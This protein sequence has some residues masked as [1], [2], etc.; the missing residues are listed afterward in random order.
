MTAKERLK[1]QVEQD[2]KA[3][4]ATAKETLRQKVQ[5]DR[6]A[7]AETVPQYVPYAAS[8]FNSL[9]QNLNV[10]QNN[11]GR[12]EQGSAIY[13]RTEEG[14]VLKSNVDKAR[15]E[16]YLS[17]GRRENENKLREA[18][19]AY[20]NWWNANPGLHETV[21][22]KATVGE[23]VDYQAG[24]FLKGFGGAVQGTIGFVDKLV[25]DDLAILGSLVDT[26]TG[27]KTQLEK[28]I[29][30]WADNAL[31]TDILGADKFGQNV[32]NSM[33]GIK[34]SKA[35]DFVG[36]IS[37]SA[38]AMLPAIATS[39]AAGM[40]GLGAGTTQALNSVVF[41]SGAAGNAAK[42]AIANGADMADA[43]QYG[44]YSGMLEVLTE[45]MFAGIVGMNPSG[46]MDD[47]VKRLKDKGIA[48]FLTNTL[49]EGVEEGLVAFLTPYVQR[50]TYNPEAA[51]ATWR[52]MMEA[53]ASG[54]A[55]SFLMNSATA[56]ATGS[57]DPLIGSSA[58]MNE[59][60]VLQDKY[61]RVEEQMVS[62]V[63]RNGNIYPQ[64]EKEK[65]AAPEIKPEEKASKGIKA[66]KAESEQEEIPR[67]ELPDV[68]EREKETA[69]ADKELPRM[70]LKAE[71]EKAPEAK[72]VPTS[73][74]SQRET[75]R[76]IGDYVAEKEIQRSSPAD[77]GIEN[78]GSIPSVAVL[79]SAAAE[80]FDLSEAAKIAQEA[81]Y[82]P[83]FVSGLFHTAE[84]GLER[85]GKAG[86]KLYIQADSSNYTAADIAREAI[87]NKS[88]TAAAPTEQKSTS[89]KMP[90]KVI[91][92]YKGGI[93]IDDQYTAEYIASG[94]V[95]QKDLDTINNTAKALG[96]KVRFTESL[97]GGK[98]GAQIQNGIVTISVS[99]SKP[100]RRLF[101]H[102]ITHRLQEL[103]PSAYNQMRSIIG[104][105]ESAKA[106]VREVMENYKSKDLEISE[107]DALDEV[108]AE[109]A[110]SLL[111]DEGAL[112]QLINKADKT[113]IEKLRE[114]FRALADKL[115]GR[116]K[117]QAERVYEKLTEAMEDASEKVSNYQ[118]NGGKKASP[119]INPGFAEARFS[120]EPPYRVGTESRDQFVADLD[121]KAKKTYQLFDNIHTIGE[122][123]LVEM[124]V[125]A[126]IKAHPKRVNITMQYM[127]ASE[128]NEHCDNSAEFAEVAQMLAD[129]LPENVKKNARI[130]NDGRIE[131]TPF[132]KEFKME[133]AFIQRIVDSLPMEVIDSTI[134]SDGR[135]IKVSNKSKVLSVGGEAYRRALV[136]ERR[137]MYRE[138]RLPTK[139]I[140]GLSKDN[141][142]ALGFVATNGKTEATGDFTTFCPQMY[143]NKGC[144]YCYRVASLK[145][146]SNNKL[147][148]ASV[149]YTGEILQLKKKDID[150]LNKTGGLRIQSNGDWMEQYSGQLAD[151]L[152]DA[153]EMGLQIKIITKEPSMIETVALLKEQGIGKNLYFNLSA[154][155]VI[156]AQGEINNQDGDGALPRN[157][158]R[159]F[160]KKDGKT[161]WKRALT[162]EEAAEYRSKYDWVNT[163]IV[164]TTIKEFIAGLRSPYVDVVTGYHGQMRNF[165][166]VSSATGETLV[167]IEAVGDAGMPRFEFIRG[168]W[169]L[170]Y[171]GKTQTHKKLAQAI[172]GAG[173]QWEY[174]IKSC[175]ITG[176]CA[177][178]KGK[179]GKLANIFGV[180]NATNRDAESLAYWQEQMDSASDNPLLVSQME[181]TSG[182]KYSLED[183]MKADEGALE[184]EQKIIRLR[185]ERDEINDSLLYDDLSEIE[186]KRLENRLV[187]VNA[188]L[189]KLITEES[190]A[191]VL[192]PVQTIL[193][194]LDRYRI[195]DL[196]SLAEQISQ[197]SW[198]DY[199]ELSRNELEEALREMIQNQELNPLEMQAPKY[200]YYVRKPA[201]SGKYSIEERDEYDSEGEVLSKEQQEFFKDSVVRDENG[202]LKV[203]YHGTSAG[204]FTV[205]E[206]YGKARYGLFGVGSYF[207]DSKNIAQS[208]TQKGKGQTPKVYEAYLNIKNPMD[209]DATANPDEWKE[210]FPEAQFP[211]NGTNEQFYRA[212]EEYFEDEQYAKWEAAEIAMEA[213]EVMG[214]D[215]IT[216]IGGGR[217]NPNGERHRVYIAFQ[218]EQ[219]K[220]IDNDRPTED[221]DIRYSIED[222]DAERDE[223]LEGILSDLQ[224]ATDENTAIAESAT[225]AKNTKE[226]I[227]V[228]LAEA[229]AEEQEKAAPELL[230]KKMSNSRGEFTGGPALQKLG[231]KI[232]NSVGKYANVQQLLGNAR[233]AKTITKAR[234]DA[235]KR[236]KVTA[237]EKNFARGIANGI[238]KESDIPEGWDKRTVLEMS[239]WY[240][241]E[242]NLGENY[243]SMLKQALTVDMD[244]ATADLFKDID[245]SKVP[246]AI[247]LN[248]RTTQRNMRKIFG[249]KGEEINK[250]LF[251]PVN[252]NEAERIRFVN[253]Q[254]DQ[255]RTFTDQTGKERALSKTERAMVQKVIEGRVVMDALAKLENRKD[256]EMVAEELIKGEDLGD[257]G[258]EFGL[259]LEE[260]DVARSYANWL[261]VTDELE[262]MD[263][264]II[265]SAADKYAAMFD[266]YYDAINEFLASH[267]YQPIG[268]IKGYVPHLQPEQNQT[269]LQNVF[270]RL[271]INTD[272]STLPTSIAGLTADYKPNK[273]WNPYFL[274]RNGT[275]T[276]FDIVEA[277]ESYVTNMADVL[278]HSDDIMRIRSAV[279][280]FRRTYSPEEIRN[281]IE[282]AENLRT[283]PQDEKIAFLTDEG[284]ISSGAGLSNADAKE[285]LNKYI[286]EQYG[287]IENTS[288][289]NNLVVYLDNYANILA[290]KQSMADRGSETALGRDILNKGNK[291]TRIFSTAAVAGNISSALNQ[292]AQLPLILSENGIV[293]TTRAL[294]DI[295]AG[296]LRKANWAGDS[297]YLNTKKGIKFIDNTGY[298]KFLNATFKPMELV[299]GIV[300]TLA[301]RSS[302]LKAIQSG[303][304][305]EDA[306]RYA[307]KKAAAIMG[308]RSKGAKPLA[309]EAKNPISAM[310]HLFQVEALNSWDHIFSDLPKDIKQ[311]AAQQGK[312]QAAKV[313]AG[314]I[315]KGLI[316]TFILNRLAEKLYGGTPA[317]FD[318][319]GITAN[320]I[321]SGQ[322]LGTNSYLEA[323]IDKVLLELFGQ[324]LFDTD[325][326]EL[327]QLSDGEFETGAAFDDLWYN[328]SNEL[329]FLNNLSALLGFGD[330]SLPLPDLLTPAKDVFSGI[331]NRNVLE[332]LDAAIQ[333][334]GE[335]AP[336]G[337]QLVKTY[338]GA[339]TLAQGGKMKGYGAKARLQYPVRPTAGNIAQAL[340]FGTGGMQENQDYYAAGGGTLTVKETALW[341]TLVSNGADEEEAYNAI[342]A[343]KG[344]GVKDYEKLAAMAAPNEWD[345]ELK[346][347]A[348]KAVVSD[349]AGYKLDTLQNFGVAADDYAEATAAMYDF[350][351]ERIA[352]MPEEDRPEKISITQD[353]AEKALKAAKN[354]SNSDKAVIWQMTNAGWSPA[355]NP[356]SSTLGKQAKK[357]YDTIKEAAE[358]EEEMQLQGVE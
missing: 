133:R 312:G 81:G 123:N 167:D 122:E 116:Q 215:G 265:Y 199:E 305:H 331:K 256:I 140:A 309:F 18:E 357:E 88:V 175:C 109:Y 276:Q 46:A 70:E 137:A 263:K 164:A 4:G 19:T 211:K 333:A 337:R 159:P 260:Q 262:T 236:L 284:I 293:N 281:A 249:E 82:E 92:I 184:M 127:L 62:D 296:N 332:V 134:V 341:K 224:A 165:E 74:G 273:K 6:A 226:V 204:G 325:E 84:G 282:W 197:S 40:A 303:M 83:V 155:Y 125:G 339:K 98:V 78:G 245:E 283:M 346:Y 228:K 9:K 200:G 207:T 95:S 48:E 161:Y 121:E 253:R 89:A 322:E 314:V 347:T 308:D 37:E 237:K 275:T 221:P 195:T 230:V 338:T 306:M 128:W 170:E 60:Q 328:A 25:G 231:I 124:T 291:L 103:A 329:P 146:G 202:N 234:Q 227:S 69:A 94:K 235:E 149:W 304:N 201:F 28:P 259:T 106:K 214:Y 90:R 198:D 34:P 113:L 23:E 183:E 64:E 52:E 179:C 353:D 119:D 186:T 297:D 277:F 85:W 20:Q 267:G 24:R 266:N 323:M 11:A 53:F 279:K 143:F 213:I 131:E 348:M 169:R 217:V 321:A 145:T 59:Q 206:P 168:G 178:C 160:M 269:A 219:I 100:L 344:E 151:M 232:T 229:E 288:K 114:V 225:P 173:L 96:L 286:E 271:G 180:K 63:F 141:W 287:K 326:E 139:S 132:E 340:L 336:G 254:L 196:Y 209:M 30:Q 300:S 43:V 182:V 335:I 14:R 118:T 126:G 93:D 188:E 250:W 41:G 268:F 108:V 210:A 295:A 115:T 218:P 76:S 54:A 44:L 51:S 330:S 351:A 148:G 5:A 31:K 156:E 258:L 317:G 86:N 172:E 194:N 49:G 55:M 298:E 150:M 8:G 205:F 57:L 342:Y 91:S 45:N 216:H 242:R 17:G 138:G 358:D 246:G 270:Q 247:V 316:S 240:M 299:D 302:Y 252:Q 278:Y 349:S 257:L 36:G 289:Y 290:G 67:M 324:T 107:L 255:V 68:E 26:T 318:I 162:V 87:A 285:L 315:S 171:E 222:A 310:V 101:G 181:E 187:K 32:E 72:P 313:L 61:G 294:K 193:D 185:N 2:R 73:S 327:M 58:G 97:M 319:F 147:T 356:F 154:D 1:K 144:F 220:N 39:G 16:L 264:V 65:P 158:D 212:M 135:K 166:R 66:E 233:A 163:R 343:T 13:D 292:T 129:L 7:I 12:S 334:I 355:S 35:R 75:A 238:Y 248:H 112:E 274:H 241:A 350:A 77:L 120:V 104:N 352:M 56:A 192:T 307:D 272:V 243:I 190:K 191:T 105:S 102:E 80:Q 29:Q 10:L 301:V 152:M 22:R 21:G 130:T 244:A 320:F 142:G 223:E 136:E 280:Y 71:E 311:I 3:R 15:E 174:Y 99:S 208:Y 239:E 110:G 42:E 189:D 111:E 50:A 27:G 203:M 79:D 176:R 33:A 157:P 354:I 117:T 177:T 345:D 261:R 47:I 251:D 38:G 153:E